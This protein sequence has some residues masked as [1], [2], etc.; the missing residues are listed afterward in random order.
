ML[1]NPPPTD[2]VPGEFLVRSLNKENF[3]LGWIEGALA[4]ITAILVS[5]NEILAALESGAGSGN[6]P[7]APGRALLGALNR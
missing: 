1:S 7:R 5:Q 6:E 3:K 4:T 2:Q